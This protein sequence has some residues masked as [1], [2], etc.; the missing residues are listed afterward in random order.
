MAELNPP[1]ALQNRTDHSALTV[2][3]LADSLTA[4]SAVVGVNDLKVSQ[5]GAGANMSVDITGGLAF[6]EG[7]ES[8]TQGAYCVRADATVVN[9]AIAASNASLGRIDS[10]IAKVQ[11]AFYSG[12]TNAWS[13]AVV[14]GTASASP[15]APALPVNSLLLANVLV[16]AA[17]SSVVNANITDKRVISSG[18]LYSGDLVCTSTTRPAVPWTGL[19]IYETDTKNQY[20]YDGTTWQLVGKVGAQPYAMAAGLQAYTMTGVTNVNITSIGFP[21]GRFTVAPR[22]MATLQTAGAG[23]SRLI[24]RPFNISQNQF[25]CNISTGDTTVTTNSGESF[26]W[27]ATQMTPTAASG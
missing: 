16:P 3:T 1:F 26:A 2:R 8:A 6:I 7:T 19:T 12:A 11:D 15:A 23:T 27:V 10:V 20:L 9:L 18:R 4:G 24:V 22:V 14:T 13:L 5:R 21:A 17:S 25:D